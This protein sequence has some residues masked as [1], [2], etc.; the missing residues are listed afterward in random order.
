MRKRHLYFFILLIST[1]SGCIFNTAN[2]IQKGSSEKSV[3]ELY[4]IPD[5]ITERSGD[6]ERRYIGGLIPGYKWPK[7]AIKRFY[8]LERETTITIQCNKVISVHAINEEEK[9]MVQ[10]IIKLTKEGKG[11]K[12]TKSSNN[13]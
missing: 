9:E 4:G 13:R 11:I 6:L 2:T 1:I 8:Y 3:L 10:N 12:G 7:S 5:A